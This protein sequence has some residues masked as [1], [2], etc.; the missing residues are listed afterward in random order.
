M[1]KLDGLAQDEGTDVEYKGQIPIRHCLDHCI[2]NDE[3][4]SISYNS[5][6]LQCYLKDKRVDS[7]TPKRYNT[8]YRTYYKI[9]DGNDKT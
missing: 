3:C 6:G 5:K 4:K 2:L 9:C 8:D 1:R 7:S